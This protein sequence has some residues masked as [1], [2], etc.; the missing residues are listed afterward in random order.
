[1]Y[2]IILLGVRF[3]NTVYKLLLTYD[4]NIMIFILNVRSSTAFTTLD[5]TDESVYF[6][7]DRPFLIISSTSWTG[8]LI[9]V[10]KY[11]F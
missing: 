11:T 9:F 5:T 2:G 1:M 4:K 7:K 8:M 6:K 10:L 3:K